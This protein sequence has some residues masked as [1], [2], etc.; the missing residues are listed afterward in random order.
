MQRAQ[1]LHEQQ[2]AT[3][4]PAFNSEQEARQGK[5]TQKK[6]KKK[7]QS[8]KITPDRPLL[9]NK[10]PATDPFLKKLSQLNLFLW[11]QPR[12]SDKTQKQQ[13]RTKRSEF[14][15]HHLTFGWQWFRST[16][17]D[18]TLAVGRTDRVLNLIV[19]QKILMSSGTLESLRNEF[20]K[21]NTGGANTQI[22]RTEAKTANRFDRVADCE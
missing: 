4:N 21:L 13:N 6:K 10:C 15:W 1:R 9:Q 3:R 5:A 2:I 18:Q 20:K 22:N 14:A 17:R 12:I 7:Y 8:V 16:D 19:R 11:T